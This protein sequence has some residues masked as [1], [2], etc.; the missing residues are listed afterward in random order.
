LCGYVMTGNR[1]GKAGCGC[2]LFIVIVCLVL[3]ALLVHP[4]SLRMLTGLLI[5]QDK[6]VPS[7]ALVVPWFLEDKSGE[8]YQEAFREFWAG[9]GKMIYVEDGQVLG[10]SRKELVARMAKQRG[11]KEDV[12]K[13]LEISPE[14]RALVSKLRERLAQLGVKKAIILV[15]EYASRWFHLLYGSE[16]GNERVVFLVKPVTLSYFKRDKWWANEFS[17]YGM[18]RELYDWGSLCLSRFKYG[19][20]S[21]ETGKR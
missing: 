4:F 8:L 18:Q 16:D 1:K 21:E 10:M 9:N 6:I 15:P 5:Y 3:A 11:I 20:K 12:V 19:Q 2:L 14:D 13:G 17:R 7:D